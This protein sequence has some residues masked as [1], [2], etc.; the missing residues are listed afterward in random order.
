MQRQK[1]QKID[2]SYR[3][4]T[5]KVAKSRYRLVDINKNEVVSVDVSTKQ[6]VETCNECSDKKKGTEKAATQRKK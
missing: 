3:T 4:T 6:D 5:K 2:Y 1:R